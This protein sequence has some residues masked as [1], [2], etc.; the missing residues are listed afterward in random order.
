MIESK[1]FLMSDRTKIEKIAWKNGQFY[2]AGQAVLPVEDAGLVH[3]ISL[4]E[5]LRTFSGKPYEKSRHLDRL[6]ESARLLD[7]PIHFTKEIIEQRIDDVVAHNRTLLPDWQEQ[8]IIV[9]ATPGLNTTYTG[10]NAGVEPTLFIHTFELPGELWSNSVN[11]GQHLAISAVPQI[12]GKCLP[13]T[14]KHRSRL[15]FHLADSEVR[16]KFPDARAILLDQHGHVRETGTANLFL[17]KNGELWTAPRHSVL[18]GVSREIVIEIARDLAI[19]VHEKDFFVHDLETADE[20]FTTSTPYGLLAVSRLNG[21]SLAKKSSGEVTRLILDAWNRKLG[22][23][24]H[25]QL[26]EIARLRNQ[27]AEV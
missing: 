15:S 8:G 18:P 16:K 9:F 24:I 4:S 14:V 13:P 23:D 3:G 19:E 6:F 12:P 2:S 25:A 11:A 17:V 5:M 1:Q 26:L 21:Q 20:I 10:K 7:L 27:A 22:L